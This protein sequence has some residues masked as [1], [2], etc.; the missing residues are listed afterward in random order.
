MN[1][2]LGRLPQMRDDLNELKRTVADLQAQITKL[3]EE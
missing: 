2:H 1:A 3:S